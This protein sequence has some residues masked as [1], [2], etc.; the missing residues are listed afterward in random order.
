M[1]NINTSNKKNFIYLS[2]NKR[3]EKQS[4][5]NSRG[6]IVHFDFPKGKKLKELV[7]YFIE[8]CKEQQEQKKRER[9]NYIT[10]EEFFNINKNKK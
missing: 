3:K 1:R 4:I 7:K 10:Q 5:Y 9:Q 2:K 6:G 8:E